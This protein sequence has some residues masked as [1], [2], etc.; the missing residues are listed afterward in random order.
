MVAATGLLLAG[1]AAYW[2]SFAGPF[3]FDDLATISQN[4]SLHR[5]SSLWSALSPLPNSGLGGRPLANLTFVVNWAVSGDS[6]G[7]Y[8]AVNLTIHLLAGLTLFG[9]V[10]RTLVGPG[11]RE[12]FGSDAGVLA[13]AVAVLWLLHPLQTASVTYISQRT[14]LLMGLCYLLTLYCFVRSLN[15]P[16]A[17]RWR[18]LAFLCCVAGMA[19]KEVMVTAPA[20]VFLY[21]AVFAAG[22]VSAAWG[23]RWRFHGA[24]AGSWL[25]LAV[26]I[27][28]LPDRGVGFGFRVSG[29]SYALTE[30]QVVVRYLGLAFWPRPLV[31]DHGTEILRWSTEAAPYVLVVA[32]LA[33]GTVV[34]W[35]RSMVGAFAG[36]WFLVVLT[37]TSSVVPIPLQPMAENRMYL[38]LAAVV[39]AVV[40]VIYRWVGRPSRWVF[41]ATALGLGWLTAQRNVDYR[42]E[43]SIWSDTVAKN[44]GSSRAHSN[45]AA[46]L[47]QQGRQ[48]QAIEECG[49]ALRI[50]PNFAEAHHHLGRVLNQIGKLPEARAEFEAA[51]R[52][53]PEYPEAHCYLAN[54]LLREGRAAEALEEVQ[55]ALRIAPGMADAQFCLGG[56]LAQTGRAAEAVDAFAAAVRVK[57][58]FAE[59]QFNLAVTLHQLG[60]IAEAIPCYE[61]ALRLQPANVAARCNLGTALLANGRVAEAIGHYELALRIEPNN[62]EAQS[63]LVNALARAGRIEDAIKQGELAVKLRPDLPGL[64]ENL[65]R[66]RAATP[67]AK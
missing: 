24:M 64:R 59:A 66:L 9:L 45:F 40:L 38:P 65:D 30:C 32:L 58:D 48:A 47:G 5:W 25:V 28:G 42:S 20:M 33:M 11:L 41:F 1:L 22:S 51:L 13:F 54:T 55:E 26:L 18:A 46:V 29:W 39:A 12:R 2:N 36:A 34:G 3:I 6:V 23:Q 62:F 50:D 16:A 19:S 27:T 44:P 67:P 7:S 35:W 49:L 31:F 43:L 21:D 10:R 37:P 53:R 56:I 60:R 61:A 17:T 14:E 57:P 4:S 63:G 15:S 52:L 8:H